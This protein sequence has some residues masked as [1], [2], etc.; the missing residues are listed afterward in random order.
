MLSMP[1]RM[2]SS[3]LAV[4]HSGRGAQSFAKPSQVNEHYLTSCA[5]CPQPPAGT[6][7]CTL[8]AEPA[9]ELSDIHY[10]GAAHQLNRRVTASC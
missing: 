6:E 4:M 8:L 9:P 7:C 5:C 3:A 10:R 1:L 2:R